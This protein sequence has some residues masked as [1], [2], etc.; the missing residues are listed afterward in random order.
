MKKRG[1]E[2]EFI[3]WI[4]RD[5][6]GTE[7]VEESHIKLLA[8]DEFKMACLS[9]TRGTYIASAMN[10]FVVKLKPKATT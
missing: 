4:K 2:L 3:S 8:E 7:P 10:S 5:G 9:I 1:T 6:S